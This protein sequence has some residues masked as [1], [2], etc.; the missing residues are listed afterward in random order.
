MLK[1]IAYIV[2]IGMALTF[3]FIAFEEGANAQDLGWIIL[4]I[5]LPLF[6]IFVIYSQN[7]DKESLFSLWVQV[8]KKKLEDQLDK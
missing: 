8:R 5:F 6:N 7:A 4:F 2:N 3:L 1:Y